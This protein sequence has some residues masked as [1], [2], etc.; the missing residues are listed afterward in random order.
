MTLGAVNPRLA[1]ISVGKGNPFG[2]P[3]VEV[4]SR[5]QEKVGAKNIYRT[6]DND[7]IDLITDGEKLW[8]RTGK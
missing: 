3:N 7:T 8:V 4:V 5:L 2:H 6:S 1:I